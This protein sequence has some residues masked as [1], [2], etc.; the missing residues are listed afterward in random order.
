MAERMTHRESWSYC[1]RVLQ[2]GVVAEKGH[3]ACIELATGELTVGA[4]DNTLRAIGF[5]A[6]TLTG[7][8]TKKARVRLFREVWLDAFDNSTAD[9]I[10]DADFGELAYVSGRSEVAKTDATGT[11]SAAGRIWGLTDTGKVLIEGGAA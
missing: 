3:L 7:D 10:G 6:E 9:P 2:S 1:E 5:F 8:G 4:T 11:R